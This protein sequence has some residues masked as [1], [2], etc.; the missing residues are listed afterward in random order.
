[1]SANPST[2]PRFQKIK[3]VNTHGATKVDALD[4]LRRH[5][6]GHEQFKRDEQARMNRAEKRAA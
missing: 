2:L 6:D 1:M 3:G 4:T 5:A